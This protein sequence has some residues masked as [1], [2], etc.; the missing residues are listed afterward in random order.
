MSEVCIKQFITLG[1]C[2]ISLVLC[3]FTRLWLVKILTLLMKYLVIFHADSCKS[4]FPPFHVEY[5]Y[6]LHSRWNISRG[7][8]PREIFTTEGAVYTVFQKEG[9]N[10]YFDIIT[11][12]FKLRILRI[13]SNVRY[14]HVPSITDG[15]L[16]WNIYFYSILHI[17]T[18]V[19]P[20]TRTVEYQPIFHGVT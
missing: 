19:F 10:I 13:H 3:I 1:H 15:I 5:Q 18:I 14:A 17:L 7:L 4:Y 6:I 20:D 8:R 12:H 2:E 16:G 11:Y 9:W